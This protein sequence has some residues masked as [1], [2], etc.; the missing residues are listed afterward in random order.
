MQAAQVDL[1]NPKNPESKYKTRLLLESESQR[2]YISRELADKM[3]LKSSP[4]S[5]LTIYTFGTTKPKT[6]ETPIVGIGIILKNGFMIH[7]KANVVPHVTGSIE[8]KPIEV[9]S[10]RK[11]IKGYDLAD[12]LP[13]KVERYRV[14]LLAGNDYYADIVSMK[15]IT[16]CDG[17]Y[18]LGSKFGWILS[19]RAQ[20]EDPDVTENSVMMLTSTSSQL[21]TQYLD[22]IK[23]DAEMIKKPNLEDLWKLETIRIT[24]TPTVS[25][26]EKAI[27][28]FNK[29]INLINGRYQTRWPW[30]DEKLELPD[31]F[32]LSYG[33]L[34]SVV[35]QLRENP[36]TLNMYDGIIKD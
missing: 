7:I 12:S 34:K 3:N 14:D 16:I 11:K 19:G 13:T 28:E 20:I 22:F 36:D 10:L 15:R 8:R 31:N 6:I 24:D 4:K 32:R 17:L 27:S 21:T 30:R 35:K 5:F 29:S 2:S 9:K 25:E 1:V 26:D 18:F 33:R 23:E